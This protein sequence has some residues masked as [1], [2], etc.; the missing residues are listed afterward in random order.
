MDVP[1]AASAV[2]AV[3]TT[4]SRAGGQSDAD[5]EHAGPIRTRSRDIIFRGAALA[6]RAAW[7]A[8]R[9]GAGD[10]RSGDA[11]LSC[12]IRSQTRERSAFR[13]W[14]HWARCS[15]S[16]S[17]SPA[18]IPGRCRCAAWP[19]ACARCVRPFLLA[20]RSASHAHAGA[21]RNHPERTRTS[22]AFPSCCRSRRVPGPRAKSFAG[23][24][25][26][27]PIAVFDDLTIAA[28]LIAVGRRARADVPRAAERAHARRRRRTL[29]R[30]RPETRALDAVRGHGPARRRERR[31]HGD[32]RLRRPRRAAPVATSRWRE[33]RGAAR[34]ER[35]RRRCAGARGRHRRAPAA[36]RLRAATRCRDVA[37]RRAVLLRP[38]VFAATAGDRST[39]AI[40]Q[41]RVLVA[42]R[43]PILQGTIDLTL[44][45][46]RITAVLGPN[47]A[48]KSTLLGCTGAGLLDP[49]CRSRSHWAIGTAGIPARG[50]RAR[51]SRSC[52][53]RR[54]SRGPSMCETLVG[55]G[56]IPYC[57]RRDADQ[58]NR[59]S[60]RASDG[61]DARIP[62]GAARR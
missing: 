19:A 20:G 28:P 40:R 43:A 1:G 52:R 9:R 10:G 33:A 6:A 50:E 46:G 23:C 62:V 7:G 2:V 58:Q 35:D 18:R 11:V 5:L 30:H 8:H 37:R 56:R 15:A 39:L 24:S 51:R 32:H 59:R 42:A 36:R 29:P 13:R 31:G 12:A 22:R 3:L 14:P 47:G 21:V 27:S 57:G 49:A 25:A 17:A 44:T 41:L 26:R 55:L 53:R 61:D 60:R 4:T 16:S 45:A 48:G 54:R 38:S 34:A